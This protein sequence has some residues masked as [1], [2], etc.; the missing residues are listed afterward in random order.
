MRLLSA[1][2]LV[3]NT[4]TDWKKREVDLK[5]TILFILIVTIVNLWTGKPQNWAGLFPGGFL[6]ILSRR[7]KEMLG[8]GDGP[9][10]MGLGWAVGLLEI[11]KILT[12]AFLLAGCGGILLLAAGKRK[13]T[14]FAFVPF[15]CIS[16]FIGEWLK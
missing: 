5:Y 11:W 1:V 8:S 4:W 14:E 3:C 6:W 12:G 16:F 13:T 9:V 2:Y 15:L 10:V 7:K